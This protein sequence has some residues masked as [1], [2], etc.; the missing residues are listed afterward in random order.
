MEKPDFEALLSSLKEIEELLQFP[1][2]P[3]HIQKASA[4]A[5]AIARKAAAGPVSNL[6]MKVISEA[7]KLRAASTDRTSLNQA[8]WHLRIALQEAKSRRS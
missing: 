8:L 4:L 6:A 5:M 3:G 2:V 1:G 7:V